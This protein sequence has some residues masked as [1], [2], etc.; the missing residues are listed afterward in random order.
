MTPTYLKYI[1]ASLTYIFNGIVSNS[2]CSPKP[3][4]TICESS[5]PDLLNL[6]QNRPGFT[7]N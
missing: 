6:E 3:N 2:V 5:F 1:S 4:L 7:L